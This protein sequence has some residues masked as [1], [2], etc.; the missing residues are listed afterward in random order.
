M[1]FFADGYSAHPNLFN[2]LNKYFI[3]NADNSK[4]IVSMDCS[5]SYLLFVTQDGQLNIIDFLCRDSILS[6]I[7]IPIESTKSYYKFRQCQFVDFQSDRTKFYI[8]LL[9]TTGVLLF[10]YICFISHSFPK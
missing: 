1:S 3:S 2:Y 4:H 10:V 7:T 5:L 6:H 9:T 8:C